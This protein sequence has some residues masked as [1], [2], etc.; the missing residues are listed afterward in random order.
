MFDLY[1]IKESCTMNIYLS[2]RTRY[3]KSR[4]ERNKKGVFIFNDIYLSKG[5]Y[6]YDNLLSTLS[7]QKKQQNL[8]IQ[9]FNTFHAFTMYVVVF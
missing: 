2:C 3:S 8:F 7:A 9:T 4:T 6:E 5:K 1:F